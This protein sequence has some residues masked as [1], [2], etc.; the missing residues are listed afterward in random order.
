M[1]CGLYLSYNS[2]F[3]APAHFCSSNFALFS[4]A[5][6]FF[7]FHPFKADGV[8]EDVHTETRPHNRSRRESQR[9]F[10]KAPL[11]GAADEE[12]EGEEDTESG[13]D[14]DCLSNNKFNMHFCLTPPI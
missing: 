7:S 5:F 14:G 3:N 8:D 1:F 9:D 13:D 2:Y 4:V 6:F 10:I 12:E 11:E